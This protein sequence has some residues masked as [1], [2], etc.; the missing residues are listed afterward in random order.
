MSA[1][2]ASARSDLF[3]ARSGDAKTG[4]SEGKQDDMSNYGPQEDDGNPLQLE[5]MLGF[6]GNYRKTVL[7]SPVDENVY[8][9]R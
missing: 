7:A 6:A 4:R 8:I 5:H 2:G 9:K 1:R 3:T